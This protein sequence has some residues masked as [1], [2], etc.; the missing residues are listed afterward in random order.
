[1]GGLGVDA[2]VAAPSVGGRGSAAAARGLRGDN[3]VQRLP[4]SLPSRPAQ[5]KTKGNKVNVGV[6]YAEKQERKFEPEKLREGRNIIGL[7]VLP[8]PLLALALDAE[9]G[10]GGGGRGGWEGTLV[11]AGCGGQAIW[12]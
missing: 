12:H 1:M 3:A 6:K 10:G 4:Q 5:A 8:L 11:P 9:L 2:S 7:Q